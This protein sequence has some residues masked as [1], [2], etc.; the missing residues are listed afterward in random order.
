MP[1]CQGTIRKR[2]I[3]VGERDWLSSKQLKLL[4]SANDKRSLPSEFATRFA[5][6]K[7]VDIDSVGKSGGERGIRTPGSSEWNQQVAESK[8]R[9]RPL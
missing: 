1:A 2:G 4:E 5:T 7:C 9:S 3:G 6:R 8:S